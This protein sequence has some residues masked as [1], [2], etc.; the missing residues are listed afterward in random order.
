VRLYVVR[1]GQTDWNRE[2]ARCTG[3]ADVDLNDTGRQQAHERGRAL[4]GRD[5]RLVITSHLR[6][7]AETAHIVRQEL[8]AADGHELELVVDPRLAETHRGDWESRRFSE[9]M[10]EEPLT[11]RAYREH[12]ETF[13]FPNGESLL[14]QQ[15]RVLAIVRDAAR[16]GRAAVLVTHGGS[17]RLLRCFLN[18]ESIDAFHRMTT[19]NGAVDEIP[20]DG[21]LPRIDAFLAAR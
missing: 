12:P 14:D 8:Q 10:M 5:V 11:W 13:R 4:A 15:R 21:L 17:I 20:V 3:W 7:A 18:G 1:H 19:H 16:D 2:P 9:I 6:R